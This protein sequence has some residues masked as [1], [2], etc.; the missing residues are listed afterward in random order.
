[1]KVNQALE[2]C[3]DYILNTSEIHQ[4]AKISHEE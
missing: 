4:D 1:M 2:N 3:M